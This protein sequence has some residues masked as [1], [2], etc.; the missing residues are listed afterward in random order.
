MKMLLNFVKTYFDENIN[1]FEFWFLAIWTVIV[2]V[3]L[4]F[5]Y[6]KVEISTSIITI[7]DMIYIV[8]IIVIMPTIVGFNMRKTTSGVSEHRP[9][10]DRQTPD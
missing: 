10:N 2:L 8:L 1:M 4:S 9:S 7:S 5:K 3:L 6:G